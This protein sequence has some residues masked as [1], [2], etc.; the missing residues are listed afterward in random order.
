MISNTIN[1][2][3]F[4]GK[5]S[6]KNIKPLKTDIV[7]DDILLSQLTNNMRRV[8]VDNLRVCADSDGSLN[9]QPGLKVKHNKSGNKITFMID[10]GE[11]GMIKYEIKKDQT[12]KTL[13]NMEPHKQIFEDCVKFIDKTIEIAKKRGAM[14]KDVDIKDV[15]AVYRAIHRKT[16]LG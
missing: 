6:G 9:V 15:D 7:K 8:N 13:P 11:N 10:A 2:Q 16:F 5:I 4:Q 14:L 1:G 12:G 3:A